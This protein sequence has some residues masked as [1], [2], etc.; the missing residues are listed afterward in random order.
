M[1]ESAVHNNT[2]GRAAPRS[3]PQPG[4][5]VS[6]IVVSYFTGPLLA[7]SVASLRAQPEIAEII[8]VDNGNR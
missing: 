4:S 6:A 1:C 3:G 5:C 2:G 8:I 7:R